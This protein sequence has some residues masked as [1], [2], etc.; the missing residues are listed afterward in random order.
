MLT[1]AVRGGPV[2]AVLAETVAHQMAQQVLQIPVAVE[3]AQTVKLV[4]LAVQV[5]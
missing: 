3:A 2:A 4:V 5:L 1:V